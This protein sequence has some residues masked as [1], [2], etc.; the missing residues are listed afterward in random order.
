MWF[1][2]VSQDNINFNPRSP[3][4]ERLEL[5][6]SPSRVNKISIHALREESDLSANDKCLLPSIS[7]HALREESDFMPTPKTPSLS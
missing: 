5:L 3:R 4:G 6:P 7:I 2:V 1:P